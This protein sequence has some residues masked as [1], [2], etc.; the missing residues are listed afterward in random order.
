MNDFFRRLAYL[1]T[2]NR[3]RRELEAEMAFHR[4][5]AE[6]SGRPEARRTFGNQL[7]LQ[8]QAREAWGWTWLDR[9]AQDL[10]FGVRIL[11]RSPGFTLMAVL[12]LAIGIGGNVS[13]FSLFD[14]IALKPLPVRDPGSLIRLERRSPTSNS[15]EMSYPS[16]AFYQDH[17]KTLSAAI[18]VLGIPPV[19]IDEDVQTTSASF[20]TPNYFSELGTKPEYGRLFDPV[21]DSS[22]AAPPAVIIGYGFWQRRFGSDPSVIGRI[23]HVNKKPATIVGITPY[24]FASLGAQHPDLW[25]PIAQLPYFVEGSHVLT[26]FSDS[27]L[28]MWGRLAPGVTAKIAEQELRTLT[29]ELRKQKP[30]AVWDK[31]YL[32]ISPGGHLQVMTPQIY[33]VAAMVGGLTLLILAVCCANLGGLLLARAVAREHEIGIRIAIGANR[34][35]IFRQLCTE[36]LLLAALGALV[37][38]ALGTAVLRVAL[39]TLDAPKWLS[40]APDWRVVLFTAGV[41]IASVTFFGLAPAL[42]IARQRRHKTIARQ[43]LV[44]AQV[45]AS[46]VLL[47]VAGLL[48]R[49]SRHALYTDPGFGYERLLTIDPQLAHHGY[50]PAQAKEYLDQ[51]QAR[52]LAA[53]GVEAVSLVAF[54]PLGHITDRE[55]H[56]INDRAVLVY[57]NYIAP[58][59]FHAMGIPL[60]AGRTFYP[61]EKNAV[62]LSDSLARQQWPGQNPIGQQLPEDDH[63]DIV[64]GV[65]GDAHIN[66]L[67]E[68]DAAEMYWAAQPDDMPSMVIVAMTNG[69][70]SDIPA[71]AR[72]I[73]D[74]LDAKVVPEIRQ[75]KALYR[76]NVAQVEKIATTVTLIGMIAVV[77]AG[78][79]IVSLVTF[80][81]SQST[82]EIAIRIALG[83]NPV[84]ILASILRQFSWPVAI[85]VLA[86]IVGTAT[87]SQILRR[88]LYG[89]S[90]LDPLSY[91]TAIAILL[92][93]FAIAALLPARRAL[94]LDLALA[95]HQE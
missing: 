3:R 73:G 16:F 1:L 11:A 74:S 8:E 45:A 54:P 28:R 32:E 89:V 91:A 68:D 29:D 46:C 63:K 25:M 77:L 24:A 21:L 81:I 65:V 66:A 22:P 80:T 19:Q 35:R 71:R 14:A 44:G 79:G 61:G 34:A 43:I 26:E 2:R 87:L 83:A 47:I 9:L 39:Q 64:I 53:P 72:S 7:R 58:G 60:L 78:V 37:G 27:N 6:R 48:V 18:G 5:M 50:K 70:A 38:L 59:F 75:L 12:I 17:S 94:N 36:S 92:A 76:D 69:S 56:E 13:A 49:A 86:G 88:V 67:S 41:A 10:H 62:I 90:N 33:Q 23:I 52:L 51:M 82:K 42:Q 95:L 15:T 85:G 57:P 55:H 4:E 20:V 84:Q 93:I 40:A 31:E 30:D